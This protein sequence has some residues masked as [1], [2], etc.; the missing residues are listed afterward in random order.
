MPTTS[1][2]DSWHSP[3]HQNATISCS[4]L[5]EQ[6]HTKPQGKR[7]TLPSACRHHRLPG[8]RRRRRRRRS[9]ARRSAAARPPRPPPGGLTRPNWTRGPC[10]ARRPLPRPPPGA[11]PAP[12]GRPTRA[13]TLR[14][15]LWAAIVKLQQ[16][17]ADADTN[18]IWVRYGTRHSSA[19]R[20]LIA[21]VVLGEHQ[22]NMSAM[23]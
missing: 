19:H 8:A 22:M 13:G 6:H 7:H 11:P 21:P 15:H 9:R 5:I 3:M 12:A 17:T 16:F 23:G 18:T 20:L 2:A 4:G 14:M 10:R 1:C